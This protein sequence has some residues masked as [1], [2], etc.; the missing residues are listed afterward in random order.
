M[1]SFGSSSVAIHLTFSMTSLSVLV[2]QS[3]FSQPYT[4][5]MLSES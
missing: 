1:L 3:C 4:L 5:E 2:S